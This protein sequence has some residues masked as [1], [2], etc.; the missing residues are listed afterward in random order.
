[1]LSLSGVPEQKASLEEE[2]LDPPLV[3]DFRFIPRLYIFVSTFGIFSSSPAA[4]DTE[5]FV[6]L[7]SA[8]RSLSKARKFSGKRNRSWLVLQIFL[9]LLVIPFFPAASALHETVCLSASLD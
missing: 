7:L 6:P 4:L 9:F 2:V 3:P 1:M 8:V 5:T